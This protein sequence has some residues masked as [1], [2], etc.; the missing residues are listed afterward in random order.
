MQSQPTRRSTRRSPRPG[1]T[2]TTSVPEPDSVGRA[3]ADAA[4]SAAER[5]GAPLLDPLGRPRAPIT[6]PEYRKGRRPPNAGKTYPAEV[7]TGQELEALLGRLS[8]RSPAGVRDRA[9]IVLLW[10]S[11]L[12]I[13]EALALDPKDL[14]LAAGSITILR[15]KGAKRRVVGIDRLGVSFLEAW[16]HARAQLDVGPQA[17]LFC[18]V[19]RDALGPGRPMSSSAFR[20]TLKRCSRDAGIR[21]RVHAH[22]LRHMHAHELAVENTPVHF[23][24]DQL[25]HRDLAMTAHYIG[26]IAPLARIKATSEREGPAGLLPPRPEPSSATTRQATPVAPTVEMPAGPLPAARHGQPAIRGQA[27]QRVLDLLASTHGMASQEQLTTALGVTRGATAQLCAKLAAEGLIVA[28]GWHRRA[29]R[30]GPPSKVW[31]L[32]PPRARLT[33]EEPHDPRAQRAPAARRGYGAQRVL[34]VIEGLGGRA[35]QAQIAREL[36]ITP[37]AVATHCQQLAHD[38]KL[39]RAGLD[40]TGSNRGSVV[41]SIRRRAAFTPSPGWGR[42]QVTAGAAQTTSR[43]A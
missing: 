2:T 21:K 17:P 14:D 5:A 37:E 26:Q 40:K 38:G 22:G 7:L 30:G 11:G 20:Q 23:I 13:G 9:L 43:R 6:L 39:D 10:R 18:T 32:A 3:R 33:L 34:D 16:L 29:G 4:L 25:G 41:W 1:P 24:R 19:T 36:G 27:L 8:E 28:G 35:S 12:R 42:M 15:G 31:R